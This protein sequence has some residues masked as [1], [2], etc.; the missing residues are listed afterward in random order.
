MPPKS[1]STPKRSGIG[2]KPLPDVP[3]P[4]RLVY[5]PP[6]RVPG[7][8]QRHQKARPGAAK[9]IDVPTF[10]KIRN[11]LPNGENRGAA[12]GGPTSETN[13]Q[14]FFTF[15]YGSACRL[16]VAESIPRSWVDKDCTMITIPEGVTKN[17]EPLTLSLRGKFF[18]PV[19]EWMQ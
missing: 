1:Y 3:W 17:G 9:Y 10:L 12:K 13:L 2:P 4:S 6:R 7:N 14:P 15:L 8:P 11:H 5:R 16:G 18:T 19:R